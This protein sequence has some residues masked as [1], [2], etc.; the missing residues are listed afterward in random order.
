MHIFFNRIDT[1][2][3]YKIEHYNDTGRINYSKTFRDFGIVKCEE[4]YFDSIFY[5]LSRYYFI[6]GKLSDENINIPNNFGKVLGNGHTKQWD[7]NGNIISE[8][9]CLNGK[10]IE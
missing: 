2:H 4:G 5:Y 1:H 8:H 10:F 9:Y 6:D 3:I 7:E